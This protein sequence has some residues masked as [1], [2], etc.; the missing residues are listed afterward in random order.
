MPP[1][2]QNTQGLEAAVLAV[3]AAI[4]GDFGQIFTGNNSGAGGGTYSYTTIGSLKVMWGNTAVTTM[5]AGAAASRIV[6]FPSFFSAAPIVVSS[7]DT[8]T[9]AY[10][11]WIINTCQSITASGFTLQHHNTGA[12]T[13]SNT[14]GLW[15]AVG[16]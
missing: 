1:D 13:T 6:V 3:A 2:N 9:G 10:S 15:V 8:S 12:G 11:D 7:S 14:V 5:G 4:K 16:I